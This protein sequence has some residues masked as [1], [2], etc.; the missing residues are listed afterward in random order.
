MVQSGN[1]WV[2]CLSAFP[3]GLV[4]RGLVF[5]VG[6]SPDG[7]HPASLETADP[8]GPPAPGSAAHGAEH[9]LRHGLLAERVG[10]DP[11]TSSLLQEQPFRKI[12]RSHCPTVGDRHCRMCDAR[13]EIVHEAG[14]DAGQP[15]F[16]IGH[17]SV[18]RVAGNGPERRL[19]GSHG[20][21]LEA[22][23]Q[24]LRYPGRQV[25]H[26]VRQAALPGRCWKACPKRLD[27]CPARRPGPQ[28]EDRSGRARACPARA[29]PA[30]ACPARA[31]P[32]RTH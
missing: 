13:L 3:L 29:C 23:P 18:G 14:N 30:R 8:D 31:C 17:R 4:C 12:G 19:T 22:G 20:T 10:D 27:R 32:E 26:A 7:G 2:I 16:A 15:A 5:L 6:F 25:A 11:Q 1:F 9:E 24:I 28:A 21:G